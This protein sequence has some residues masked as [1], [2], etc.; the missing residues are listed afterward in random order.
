M[1][2]PIRPSPT[3]PS[4]MG[5]PP[6][7]SLLPERSLEQTT[8]PVEHGRIGAWQVDPE[9]PA[10]RPVQRDEVAEG[11]GHF[12]GAEREWLSGNCEVWVRVRGDQDELPAV[13]P[14]LVELARRVEIP[15]AE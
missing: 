13:R 7:R 15:R 2:I 4:S 8:G 1:F 6:W 9:H 3:N 12:Q 10:P 11:L 5:P 14:S